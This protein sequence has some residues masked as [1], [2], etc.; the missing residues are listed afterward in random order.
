[1]TGRCNQIASAGWTG[2]VVF[3][4]LSCLCGA[5]WADPMKGPWQEHGR[6]MRGPDIETESSR[7]G[8]SLVR[9][10][11]RFVS[12]ID[13]TRCPM[14]PSCSQYGLTCFKKHGFFIGWTMIWDRLYRCG[15]DE[16]RHSPTVI[17]D[18]EAKCYDPVAANDFWWNHK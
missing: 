2:I 17:I 3:V 7:L 12:P 18:G 1:M 13:G 4:M 10:Y 6:Q 16:L 5:A 9:L 15:R 14:Y 8:V 11:R